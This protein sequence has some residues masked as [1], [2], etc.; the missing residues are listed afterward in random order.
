MGL[1]C[2]LNIEIVQQPVELLLLHGPFIQGIE[3]TM[4]QLVRRPASSGSVLQPRHRACQISFLLGCLPRGVYG[5]HK[6][7]VVEWA[8]AGLF[9]L[10]ACA[11]NITC[12]KIIDKFVHPSPIRH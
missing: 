12:K 10:L 2:P 11:V 4:L 1:A 7:Q 3:V 6:I 5:V 9:L 8:C